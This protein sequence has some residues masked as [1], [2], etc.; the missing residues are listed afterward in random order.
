MSAR[1]LALVT[2]SG[3]R[4]IGNYVIR[5][6]ARRGYDAAVHYR[7]SKEEAEENCAEIRAMGMRA[8]AFQADFGNPEE[9]AELVRRVIASFGRIDLL[10]T[11]ASIW[12]EK[13]LEDITPEDLYANFNVNTLGTFLCCQHAGLQMV[14]QPEGGAIITM[15]DWAVV[16]PYNHYAA[17][18][19]S[20][21][22]IETLTIN[23]ANELA[24][25]NPKIRVN[26]VHPGPMMVPE[27][28]SEENRNKI[29]ARSLAGALGT[30]E[31][32]VQT[33]FALAENE[34]V[35]GVCLPVDGG[36]SISNR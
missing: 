17:Y 12:E 22:A 14:K 9:A 20:K 10:V 33:V 28:V 21:G 27:S 32:V 19:L 2:G 35:T 16:R 6:A 3:K 29:I 26:C 34:Y 24:A 15:G 8:E 4:R 30:P 18:N 11:A 23:F 1:K 25:R 5:E 7:T 13:K 31:Q 36:R